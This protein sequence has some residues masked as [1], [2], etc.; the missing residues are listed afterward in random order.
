MLGIKAI[1]HYVPETKRDNLEQ[2]KGLGRDASFIKEKIGARF[3]PVL[4][5]ELQTSDLAVAAVRRLLRKCRLEVEDLDCLCLCTQ[6]PDLEG[7]PHTS[8]IVHSKLACASRC[9]AFDVSL[10]CSGYVYGLN[11]LAGF[12]QKTDLNRG[13][14]IT[15]DPYSR[16]VDPEDANTA[17]L[18]GDAATATLIEKDGIFALGAATFATDGGRID[19][20][21]KKNGRLHMNGRQVFNFAATEVP[22]QVAQL[23]SASSLSKDEIDLFIFHQGS[24]F[25]VE[26]LARKMRLP[27]EKVPIMLNNTGNTVSS[28][29]PLILEKYLNR[30]DCRTLLL[31]GFGVG[32]SVAS[33][34]LWRNE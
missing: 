28:S 16:I 31:S 7:L 14:L 19:V 24:K 12:M 13:V 5:K 30:E 23:L 25:I 17:L 27:S 9:A 26:T 8:A 34:I 1:A 33:M 22:R 11:I 4:A 29:I 6:T 10:G 15:A 21:H 32:L 20:L 2:A 3:L 18:F